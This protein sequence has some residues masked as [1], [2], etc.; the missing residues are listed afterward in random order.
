MRLIGISL[1]FFVILFLVAC[2]PDG[3]ALVGKGYADL[4][5]QQKQVFW[6]CWTV[7]CKPLFDEAQKTKDF[8]AYRSCSLDCYDFATEATKQVWCTDSDGDS[9]VTKGI[10]K[11]NIYPQGK[12]DLCYTFPN[13]KTYLFE[14]QCVN[15]EYQYIQKNCAELGKDYSCDKTAGICVQKATASGEAVLPPVVN[16]KDFGAIGDGNTDDGK[17]FQNALDFIAGKGGGKLYLPAGN[18]FIDQTLL[19]Y[20]QTEIYGEG[21]KTILFRGDKKSNVP[22]Y[23]GLT[24]CEKNIGFAGRVLFWNA[25]YNCGNK[26]IYLHDFMIDGS[27]VLTVPGSVTIAFSAVEDLTIENLHLLNVPQDG[28]F[29]RNG[30][31]HTILRNNVIDGFCTRWYNGGGINIEM[32]TKEGDSGNFPTP[33]GETVLIEENLILA[34][35]PNFCKEDGTTA[36]SSNAQCKTTCGADAAV[37]ILATWVNGEFAPRVKM[38]NNKIEVTDK[39]LGIGCHGCRD[40]IIDGNTISPYESGTDWS[41]LFMGIISEHPKAGPS[42]NLTII[43]NMIQGN[44]KPFDGRGILVSSNSPESKK[45]VLSKNTISNKN[46]VSNLAALE[47]RGYNDF[48]VREN[49]LTGISTV[50]GLVIGICDKNWKQTTGGKIESNTISLNVD[51]PSYPFVLRKVADLSFENNVLSPD[52]K[53]KVIC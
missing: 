6:Q 35:G 1:L 2:S 26:K 31:V 44:G 13:G 49:T 52:I 16:V 36:C 15:K 32:H 37:G 34:R 33:P 7:S 25:K 40:S 28:I 18:Y 11:T 41:G 12:E 42:W 3:E 50:P 39:H 10:V 19:I 38:S 21:D 14:G 30:G 51:N 22:W 29:V 45:L 8:A 43:N 20:N 17:A 24:N 46:I 23:G 53:P 27:K 47:V 4:T 9:Y 5:N 48:E